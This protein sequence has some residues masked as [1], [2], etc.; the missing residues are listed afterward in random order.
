MEPTPS[1]TAALRILRGLRAAGHEA[2]FAGGAVRDH[3]LGLSPADVDI[4]TSARPEEV[5]ALHPTGRLVGASFGVVVVPAPEAAIEVAT[6]RTEGPYLDGRRPASVRYGTHEEDARRRDFTI[7][8]LYLDPETGEIRDWVDGRRDLE[9]RR[10][11][12]IGDPD[13]R[14]EEDHLR[15]LRAVRFGAQ[16]GLTIEPATRDAIARHAPRVATVAAERV[17]DELA[18]MLCGANPSLAIDL[19]HGLGLLRVILPEVEAMVG[20]EQPPEY[21][22]EGDVFT[23]TKELFLHLQAPSVEL[24]FG[25]LLHDVG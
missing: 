4:A 23:H 7:N 13:R 6:F 19:L 8:G 16:L 21:H 2:W 9:Q 3:L 11:R 17:R 10:L 5:I 25:A 15:L 12:A 24:A 1:W 22:P 20:V 18:R 14:F